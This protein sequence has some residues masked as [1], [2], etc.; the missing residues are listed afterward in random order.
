MVLKDLKVYEL[1]R[2]EQ[3]KIAT[4]GYLID[5]KLKICCTLEPPWDDN[6]KDNPLTKKNEA[7]CIPEGMYLCK[8]YNGVA[9]KDV[10]EVTKVPG[11]T[12][13]LIHSGNF[14]IQ[15]KSCILV[16][17]SHMDHKGIPILNNSVSTLNK[18]RSSLP[19]HFWL[20]IKCDGFRNSL[21]DIDFNKMTHAEEMTI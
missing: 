12:S 7:S 9:F 8:K 10:W 5:K 19:I 17:E 6:K 1:L 2:F 21:C 18:L 15:S 13:V 20:K 16:G 4:R 11:K 14:A 3:T